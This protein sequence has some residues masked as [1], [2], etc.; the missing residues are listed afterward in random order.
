MRGVSLYL[1]ARKPGVSL[2]ESIEKSTVISVTSPHVT[3]ERIKKIFRGADER[4]TL[5]ATERHVS[6]SENIYAMEGMVLLENAA[7]AFETQRRKL[8]R[9]WHRRRTAF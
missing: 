3:T 1:T 2:M 5:T 8:R 7:E 9:W 4:Q 6:R